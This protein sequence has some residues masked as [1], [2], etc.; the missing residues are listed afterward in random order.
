MLKNYHSYN[1]VIM[2]S[3]KNYLYMLKENNFQSVPFVERFY[4]LDSILCTD[5]DYLFPHGCYFMDIVPYIRLGSKDMVLLFVMDK[6]F[7]Y[8]FY[9]GEILDS[10]ICRMIKITLC[11]K[12]NNINEELYEYHISLEDVNESH[13][14]GREFNNRSYMLSD[15]KNFLFDLQVR[16]K[17]IE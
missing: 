12:V 5:L 1:I 10:L 15:V 13:V 9:R 3:F 11:K 8:P 16:L 14:I 4:G 7:L 17:N 6:P 2:Y